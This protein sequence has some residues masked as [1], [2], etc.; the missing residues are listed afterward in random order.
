[1]ILTAGILGLRYKGNSFEEWHVLVTGAKKCLVWGTSSRLEIRTERE[2]VGHTVG[3][4]AE[5]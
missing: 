1:M 2:A 4:R 3:L 5:K